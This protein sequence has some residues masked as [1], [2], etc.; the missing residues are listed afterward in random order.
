MIKTLHLYNRRGTWLF[1]DAEKQIV[2]EPFVEGSSEII[3][4]I[5]KR[6]GCTGHTISLTFSNL[7]FPTCQHLLSWKCSRD[8]GTWNLYRVDAFQMGGWL[9][10]VLLQYFDKVP[11]KL[12]V[13]ITG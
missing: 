8:E 1:D 4:E 9:C 7:P 11:E 10:P 12:Y 5:Q 3:T 6:T 2:E 13:T